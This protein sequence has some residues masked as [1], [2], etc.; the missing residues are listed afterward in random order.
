MGSDPLET[1]ERSE[2]NY[3]CPN[4]ES[5]DYWSPTYR[6]RACS[7]C[8]CRGHETEWVPESLTADCPDCGETNVRTHTDGVVDGFVCRSCYGSYL[9]FE[10]E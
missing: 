2:A 10:S 3:R 6:R 9:G 7:N 4:C 5:D 1:L 8:R